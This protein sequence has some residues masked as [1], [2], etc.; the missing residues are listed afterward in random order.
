MSQ[1]RKLERLRELAREY[2][3]TLKRE[4]LDQDL[5]EPELAE[6]VFAEVL[7]EENLMLCNLQGRAEA[8]ELS[9]ARGAMPRS[10]TIIPA[11]FELIV[12]DW[13][14][15]YCNVL[16]PTRAI[17]LQLSQSNITVPVRNVSVSANDRL[18]LKQPPKESTVLPLL[19]REER[20]ERLDG[21]L[22][23]LRFCPELK[24]AKRGGCFNCGEPHSHRNCPYRR[25][26][27]C[28]RC[29]ERGMTHDECPRCYPEK[30]DLKGVIATPVPKR[31]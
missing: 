12:E 16:P 10:P 29:G 3:S 11:Q 2:S 17:P 13:K 31:I 4:G 21:L 9:L 5:E 25:G 26:T 15:P 30:Y 1:Q 24:S 7:R 14:C 19:T 23:L 8:Q 27:F 18:R 22:K 6:R 20:K 28:G